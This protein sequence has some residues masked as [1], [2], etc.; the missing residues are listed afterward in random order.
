MRSSSFSSQPQRQQLLWLLWFLSYTTIFTLVS[1]FSAE[2]DASNNRPVPSV[3]PTRIFYFDDRSEAVTPTTTQYPSSRPSNTAVA[4]PSPTKKPTQSPTKKPTHSSAQRLTQSQSDDPDSLSGFE[5]VNFGEN[6]PPNR[7]PLDICQGD[8]DNHRDCAKGL[9]C[10]QREPFQEVPGCV[11]GESDATATSYCAEA[12]PGR[13]VDYGGTPPLTHS[14]LG[15]CQGDCDNDGD[16][17]GDLIC[18]QRDENWTVPG[19]WFRFGDQDNSKT[20]YCIVAT[21]TDPPYFLPIPTP[22]PSHPA[23]QLP[24]GICQ[25]DCD[26]H[27]D[28]AKGLYCSTREPFEVA[29]GCAN[30]ELDATTTSYC[31]EVDPG[32]LVDYGGTPPLTHSSLGECQGDCDNDGD[33]GDGLICFQ[34]DENETVPGCWF[35]DQD[36]SKTDYCIV[37]TPTDPPYFL[38]TPPPDIV[39]YRPENTPDPTQVPVTNAPVTPMDSLSSTLLTFCVIADVP[40]YDDEKVFLPTQLATQ[41]EGCEFLVHLGDIMRGEVSCDEEHYTTIKNIMLESKLPAFIVPG[42]NEWNDCGDESEIEDAWVLWNTHLM[43][44]EN[45]W[46]HTLDVIRQPDYEENF[47]FI[48]KRVLIVGLNIVGGRVHDADE[49]TS[50]LLGE[51]DWVLQIVTMNVLQNNNVDGIIIMAHAKPTN[52]NQIFFNP[53]RDF[54]HDELRD[55]VPV[56]YLHGDGHSFV[57]TPNFYNQ[58]NY[59]RIQHEGGVRDPVLK[60]LADPQKLGPQVYDAFQYDQQ[61]HLK[62]ERALATGAQN[63]QRTGTAENHVKSGTEK[64]FLRHVASNG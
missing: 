58:A 1:S 17:K 31:V 64:T 52:E 28:C 51:V 34:R 26:Y 16:C 33:C 47:Y 21:R 3:S 2:E 59:V 55:E 27:W 5:L 62:E 12:E 54:I 24:L 48:R 29:P 25:G 56:M 8:C 18:F 9:Y 22:P 45:N 14:S 42:D 57:H 23:N 20:D 15:E 43:H 38:P 19:C 32:K 30:V 41:M 49:W 37:A 63:Q 36:D 60:I 53:L 7:L 46:N 61:L 35:G 40:Y 4:T 11:T 6:L 39:T 10:L 13:L 44:L 50:R